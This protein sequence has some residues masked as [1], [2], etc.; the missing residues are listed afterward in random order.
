VLVIFS[1]CFVLHSKNRNIL[2]FCLVSKRENP[3][4]VEQKTRAV[5][6]RIQSNQKKRVQTRPDLNTVDMHIVHV[7]SSS[8]QSDQTDAS[9][10]RGTISGFSIICTTKLC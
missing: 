1:I 2:G 5:N 6:V 7:D 9:K 8:I 4:T 10:E 3:S